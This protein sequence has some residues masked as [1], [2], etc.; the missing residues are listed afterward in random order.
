ML[1][2]STPF[3]WGLLI[4]LLLGFPENFSICRRGFFFL[5]SVD[6][7]LLYGCDAQMVAKE[8]VGKVWKETFSFCYSV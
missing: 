6:G 1:I 4:D 5:L 7:K 2:L 8:S 3:N